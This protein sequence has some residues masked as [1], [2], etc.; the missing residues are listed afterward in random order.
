MFEEMTENSGS[1]YGALIEHHARCEGVSKAFAWCMNET[2]I[3]CHTVAGT[4]LWE[5]SNRYSSHS[6]NIIKLGTQYYHVD[7]AADNMRTTD[8]E[9]TLP[10]YAFLNSD[11]R[12]I[13]S[14]RTA[15][16]YF[17]E[18]GLPV[19]SDVRYN[20]HVMNGQLIP[21]CGS[22]EET[23]NAVTA[24][25]GQKLSADSKGLVSI[26]FESRDDMK[27]CE[28]GLDGWLKPFKSGG[29]V[30]DM[31]FNDVDLCAA[32]RAVQNNSE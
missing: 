21:S 2:G 23:E 30:F 26:R 20:Y 8:A 15:G 25:I 29:T 7:I 9:E 5:N 19:C 14:T 31:A 11:D 16:Q 12:Q 17:S 22:P 32:V 10:L 1:V 24:L 3:E 27:I 28:D 13:Y 4:P 6:W 18:L